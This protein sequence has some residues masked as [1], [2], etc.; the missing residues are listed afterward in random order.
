VP[1]P[2]HTAAGSADPRSG[3][4]HRHSGAGSDSDEHAGAATADRAG[5]DADTA[6]IDSCASAPDADA[7]AANRNAD[8]YRHASHADAATDLHVNAGA[9]CADADTD[10]GHRQPLDT[11]DGVRKRALLGCGA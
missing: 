11:N 10:A 3:D 7:V 5:P 1:G 2:R 8:D 9:C 4:G 6:D